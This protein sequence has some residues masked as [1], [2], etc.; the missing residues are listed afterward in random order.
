MSGDIPL[1]TLTTADGKT[2]MVRKTK[3]KFTTHNNSQ[4]TTLSDTHWAFGY[5]NVTTTHTCAAESASRSILQLLTIEFANVW[6]WSVEEKYENP[7][8]QFFPSKFLSGVEVI[9]NE[10]G[11]SSGA[12]AGIALGIFIFFAILISGFGCMNHSESS[13]VDTAYL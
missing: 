5:G 9:S 7:L 2:A 13:T 11:L 12:I 6:E 4:L 3:K 8:T 10:V 1:M